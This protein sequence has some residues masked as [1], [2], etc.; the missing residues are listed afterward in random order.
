[1]SG[2]NKQYSGSQDWYHLFKALVFLQKYGNN[3]HLGETLTAQQSKTKSLA[4]PVFICRHPESWALSSFLAVCKEWGKAVSR[5]SPTGLWVAGQSR[6]VPQGTFTPN[7]VQRVLFVHD[8][9]KTSKPWSQVTLYFLFSNS[10]KHLTRFFFLE[11]SES[12][13]S[14]HS[15]LPLRGLSC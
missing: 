10:H 12:T 3:D 5:Y 7:A 4:Q 13:S 14:I 9:K 2:E 15:P 6:A 8:I 11:H 1:M